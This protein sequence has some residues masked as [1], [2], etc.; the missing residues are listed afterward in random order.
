MA[1]RLSLKFSYSG[2]EQHPGQDRK[3]RRKYLPVGS[4]AASLRQTVLQSGSG[5]TYNAG[6][7]CGACEQGPLTAG[8]LSPSVQGG[9]HSVSLFAGPTPAISIACVV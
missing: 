2:E 7:G 3:T 8:K 5:A 4:T 1:T 6:G 9:I